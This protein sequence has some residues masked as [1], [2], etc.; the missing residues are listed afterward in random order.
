MKTGKTDPGA[1][2]KP[3]PPNPRDP[4]YDDI[5]A[6]ARL[7]EAGSRFSEFRLKSGDIEVEVKRGSVPRERENT[8]AAPPTPSKPAAE[9]PR[10]A[11]AN[12]GAESPA[13]LPRGTEVI[14]APMVGTFYRAPDPSAPPFVQQGSRVQPDTI[15]CIL[16]VMKLMNSVSAGVSGVVTHIF[17]ENAQMVEH[18]QPLIAIKVD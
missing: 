7:I 12:D 17:V 6:I 3:L 5:L 8:V 11:A 15:L 1:M 2:T 16:E 4:T 13:E 9:T 14:R 10:N 18:G